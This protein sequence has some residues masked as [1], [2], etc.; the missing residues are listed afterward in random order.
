MNGNYSFAQDNINDT[1]DV[2]MTIA[3]INEQLEMNDLEIKVV[4]LDEKPKAVPVYSTVGG[5]MV[6]RMIESENLK[7]MK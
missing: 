3:L 1:P 4:T 6:R 7:R 2:Q 5:L